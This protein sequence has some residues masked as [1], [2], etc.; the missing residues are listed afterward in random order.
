MSYGSDNSHVYGSGNMTLYTII[1]EALQRLECTTFESQGILE[2]RNLQKMIRSDISIL[3]DDLLVIA[4]EFSYWQNSGRS[5]DLLC[6]TR[7]ADLAVVELKRTQD[8]GH[9]ELQAIRYAAMVSNMTM[10]D[11]IGAY[12]REFGVSNEIATRDIYN[13]VGI[14]QAKELALSGKVQ[15][16]LASADF[17]KEVA[18]TVLWLNRAGLDITCF[19]L[20]PYRLGERLL[21]DSEQIIPIPEAVEYTIKLR[22]RASEE[23]RLD[24]I[25]VAQTATIYER[26]WSGLISLSAEEGSEI[27]PDRKMLYKRYLSSSALRGIPGISIGASIGPSAS[28]VT[29][30]I[31]AGPEKADDNKKLFDGLYNLKSEI[32][33]AV[34]GPIIWDRMDGRKAARFYVELNSGYD[35]PPEAWKAIQSWMISRADE[36]G[37]AVRRAL[38]S[39]NKAG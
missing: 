6:L 24:A 5:I 11:V 29:C 39:V 37:G 33:A 1:N 27:F 30:Y 20:T 7:T 9:A 3:R 31:E 17:S 34:S 22:E 26:F 2:R 28:E 32:Q 18:S 12:A 19:R 16:V 38:D 35:S 21:I 14:D 13:F 36:L 4:E 10:N 25:K 15:I 8:A 23:R